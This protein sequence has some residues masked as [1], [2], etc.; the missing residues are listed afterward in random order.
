MLYKLQIACH[1]CYYVTATTSKFF[2]E[3]MDTGKDI[4]EM[5]EGPSSI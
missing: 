3:S 1:C 4:M 5:F 2:Y